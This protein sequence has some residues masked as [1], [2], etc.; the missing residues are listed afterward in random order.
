MFLWTD[1]IQDADLAP[2]SQSKNVYDQVASSYPAP[3]IIL[4][5]SVYNSTVND[6]VPFGVEKLKRSG[7]ELVSVGTCMGDQ[8]EWPYEWVGEPQTGIWRC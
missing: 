4:D 3:H 8:G 1:D 6:V 2:V 5:H 7:Y